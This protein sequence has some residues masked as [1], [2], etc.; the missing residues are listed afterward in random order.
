MLTSWRMDNDR[1][2]AVNMEIQDV[3]V[4]EVALN[5]TVALVVPFAG[6]PQTISFTE[7]AEVGEKKLPTP[8][9]VMPVKYFIDIF[10]SSWC[11]SFLALFLVSVRFAQAE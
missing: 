9:A 7:G 6:S 8:C 3:K 2:A 4:L 1:G 10:S 5:F 11:G